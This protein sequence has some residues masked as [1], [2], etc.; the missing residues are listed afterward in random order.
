MEIREKDTIELPRY[1]ILVAQT[2]PIQESLSD[3]I[4]LNP[5]IDLLS[6]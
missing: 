1:E 6:R 4:F 5:V 3:G 2:R